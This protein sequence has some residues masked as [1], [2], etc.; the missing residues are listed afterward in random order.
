MSYGN[1]FLLLCQPTY[2]IKEKILIAQNGQIEITGKIRI[3]AYHNPPFRNFIYLLFLVCFIFGL[4]CFSLCPSFATYLSKHH[5]RN[6]AI[7]IFPLLKVN[8]SFFN[9]LSVSLRPASRARTG[10]RGCATDVHPCRQ[11]PDQEDRRCRS[12]R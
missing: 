6:G 7:F 1:E 11:S 9:T 5:Y 10:L 3:P 2:H 8:L 4:S 12:R